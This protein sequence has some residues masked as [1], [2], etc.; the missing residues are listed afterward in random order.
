VSISDCL[1]KQK[2]AKNFCV[3][4]DVEYSLTKLSLTKYHIYIEHEGNREKPE[5][6]F[7]LTEEELVRTF[8][9]PFTEKRPFWFCGRLLNPSQVAKAIIFNS[10]E[11]CSKL[12]LP[13]REEIAGHKDKKFVMDYIL[14]GK[15][16]SVHICTEKFLPPTQ[17]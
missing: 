3:Q 11:D 2:N 4:T 7:N 17:K 16:K 6:R 12:V 5:I 13:N 15:V 1:E 14:R 10:A 9:I 8:V